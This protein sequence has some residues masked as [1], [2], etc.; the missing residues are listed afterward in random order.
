MNS[1]KVAHLLH[2]V[3]N[4]ELTNKTM[5]SEKQKSFARSKAKLSLAT[6]SIRSGKTWDACQIFVRAVLALPERVPLKPGMPGREPLH[7][8]AAQTLK[9]L[10][11]ELIPDIEE[12]LLEIGFAESDFGYNRSSGIFEMAGR[13][14]RV[15]AGETER[16]ER[17]VRSLTICHALLDEVTLMPQTFLEAALSRMSYA[18]SRGWLCTNPDEPGHYVK[19][20]LIDQAEAK[21]IE[22]HEFRLRDNPA[23]DDEVIAY[24]QRLYPEGSV[25]HQRFIEGKWVAASGLIWPEFHVRAFDE[26]MVKQGGIRRVLCDY[27]PGGTTATLALVEIEDDTFSVVQGDGY[28]RSDEGGKPTLTD[29]ELYGRLV[30]PLAVQWEAQSCVVDPSAASWIAYMRQEGEHVTLANNAVLEGLGF[31]GVALKAGK[32]WIADND[33]TQPLIEEIQGYRW[34]DDNAP[35]KENDHWCDALR[36]GIMDIEEQTGFLRTMAPD[37]H[38]MIDHLKAEARAA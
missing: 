31:T 22:V 21:A 3:S 28:V 29:A 7:L 1:F 20:E 37:E 24:Y 8:I 15:L 4:S 16:S 19:K 25:F 38:N 30:K 23:L 11:L 26:R 27:G 35:V 12:Y 17:R 33:S 5:L 10:E 34:G 14:C 6:G 9:T 36:Y 2:I 13:R 32:V 18:C